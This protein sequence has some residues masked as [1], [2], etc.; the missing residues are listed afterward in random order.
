MKE[1]RTDAANVANDVQSKL[2][3]AG[4]YAPQIERGAGYGRAG[5]DEER[6]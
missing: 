6:V 4:R 5:S 1:M 3:V 2:K